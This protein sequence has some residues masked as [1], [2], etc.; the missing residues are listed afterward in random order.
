MS[1][2][3][4]SNAASSATLWHCKLGHPNAT[5]LQY[6]AHHLNLPIHKP[7]HFNCTSCSVNKSHKLPFQLSDSCAKKPFELMHMDVWGPAPV[8]S[9]RGFK[10]YLVILDDFSRYLWLFP[11]QYKSDVQ[12]IVTQFTAYVKTQF[13][14]PVQSFRSDNGGE[15]INKYLCHLFLEHGL[16]HQT[17][18]P[19]T[20]E[21]NGRAERSHR[22]LMET[23]L[24]LLH[25]ANMPIK[26]WMEALLTSVYL[27][28]RLPHSAIQ[29]QVLYTLLFNTTPD[30][31]FLK[32]FGCL[33][34]PWLKPYSPHKLSFK[35]VPC[36]LLGYC[37]TTKGYRCY[38]PTSQKVY[39]S[40]HVKFVES[41]FSYSSITQPLSSSALP[42]CSSF[43]HFDI[44]LASETAVSFSI[45]S[46]PISVTVPNLTSSTSISSSSPQPEPS[47]SSSSVVFAPDPVMSQPLRPSPLATH[48]MQTRSKHGIFKPVVPF[49][50]SHLLLYL[51]P[52]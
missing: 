41:D 46:V 43:L 39:I 18:C 24:T 44:P 51:N 28:N 21:Q 20:P 42:S 34:F 30:Y 36:V 50:L 29:N 40:R 47:R 49:F 52:L 38:D 23:T 2:S 26:F 5:L 22:H 31:M 3:L 35:S 37:P 7:F 15:F 19:H 16:V 27:I 1:D 32:P 12:D 48:P 6:L 25:Q 13:H 10:Y 17:S 4:G 45:P 11:M 33:Y 9:F 14:V 8:A